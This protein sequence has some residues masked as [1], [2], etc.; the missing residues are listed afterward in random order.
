M[1]RGLEVGRRKSVM[2]FISTVNDQLDSSC[3]ASHRRIQFS[4]AGEN[5]C[6]CICVYF[7]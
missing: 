5:L 1:L 3:R 2:S 7:Q 4:T 6:V